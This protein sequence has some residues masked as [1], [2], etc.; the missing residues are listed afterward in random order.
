MAERIAQLRCWRN[1]KTQIQQNHNNAPTGLPS[2]PEYPPAAPSPPSHPPSNSPPDIDESDN[3]SNKDNLTTSTTTELALP[4]PLL[5]QILIDH[6]PPPLPFSTVLVP[7]FYTNTIA[8]IS[9]SIDAL[10]ASND[11][12]IWDMM[13]Q[14][15]RG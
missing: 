10:I 9:S 8:I 13:P 7:L 3:D 6:S 12:G 4:I 5:I 1:P 2:I 11:F 14:G 15:E